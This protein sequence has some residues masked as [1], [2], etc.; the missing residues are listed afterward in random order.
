MKKIKSFL[1]SEKGKDM[2]IVVIVILVGLGSFE[3][4][5]LSKSDRSGGIKIEYTDENEVKTDSGDVLGAEYINS[6][7]IDKIAVTNSAGGNFFASSRGKKYYPKDCSA[8]KSI[9]ETNK[10]WFET[11]EEA[12]AAGY[13]LSGSCR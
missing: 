3:L 12:E 10:I 8:G 13:E 2:L 9:V 5:R 4:G 1:E 6:S 7:Q 11:R